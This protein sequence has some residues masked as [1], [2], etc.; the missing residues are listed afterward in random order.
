M[1]IWIAPN[2]NE[3]ACIKNYL[4][5][6]PRKSIQIEW[7][8]TTGRRQIRAETRFAHRIEKIIEAQKLNDCCLF[9]RVFLFNR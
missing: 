7:C 6:L 5:L 4:F 3:P 8:I 2:F 9:M 1:L